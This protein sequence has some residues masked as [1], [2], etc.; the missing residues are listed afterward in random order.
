MKLKTLEPIRWA[1]V[2]HLTTFAIAVTL[3][4]CGLFQPPP[5]PDAK[6]DA[7][8]ITDPIVLQAQTVS[9][10]GGINVVSSDPAANAYNVFPGASFTINFNIPM[11]QPSV[12]RAVSLFPSQYGATNPATFGKLNLTSMC[13]GRWRV[14]NPN[15]VSVSFQWDVY[16]KPE[17]GVGVVAANSE[18]FFQ[19]SQGEK[20]VRLFVGNSQQNTKASTPKRCTDQLFT[21]DWAKDSKSVI[22]TPASLLLSERYTLV[23][24]TGAR[25]R[26]ESEKERDDEDDK[27]NAK[28][29][30][31]PFTLFFS[32]GLPTNVTVEP[33]RENAV[34]ERRTV[35]ENQKVS[36]F[37]GRDT[38]DQQRDARWLFVSHKADSFIRAI[39]PVQ[40]G[41]NTIFRDAVATSDGRQAYLIVGTTFTDPSSDSVGI[42]R[43][44]LRTG[45]TSRIFLPSQAGLLG[46]SN[47]ALSPNQQSLAFFG[48]VDLSTPGENRPEEI[49]GPEV[50]VVPFSLSLQG[51]TATGSLTTKPVEYPI[52][53]DDGVPCFEQDNRPSMCPRPTV[54]PPVRVQSIQSPTAIRAQLKPL[55]QFSGVRSFKAQTQQA[56][57]LPR[58]RFPK[59]IDKDG[60]I[61]DHRIDQY[62]RADNNADANVPDRS[63][64]SSGPFGC[65]PT[66]VRVFTCNRRVSIIND[67]Y[68]IDINRGGGNTDC[69]DP[70]YAA[71]AGQ[72]MQALTTPGGYGNQVWIQH[73]GTAE[74]LSTLYAHLSRRTVEVGSRV[75]RG[76]IIGYV[77]TTG[78]SPSC[79]LHFSVRSGN[80]EIASLGVEPAT[81]TYP[82]EGMGPLNRGDGDC[83]I[84]EM[85]ERS[86]RFKPI[87]ECDTTNSGNSGP[88]LEG[89]SGTTLTAYAPNDTD[90]AGS[91]ATKNAGSLTIKNTGKK[92]LNYK[93]TLAGQ[94]SFGVVR[95]T[96]AIG[97][98]DPAASKAIPIEL[99]CS[100]FGTDKVTVTVTSDGGTG[101]VDVPVNCY[102]PSLKGPPPPNPTFVLESGAS[103]QKPFTAFNIGNIDL[104]YVAPLT[105][106]SPS[107]AVSS[108]T[109]TSAG[110]II[111]KGGATSFTVTATCSGINTGTNTHTIT[112][113]RKD[114]VSERINLPVIVT[115]KAPAAAAKLVAAPADLPLVADVGDAINGEFSFGNSGDADMSFA[116]GITNATGT[117]IATIAYNGNPGTSVPA[118]GT[119][120]Q[121]ITATCLRGG[122]ATAVITIDAQAAGKGTTIV[123][124][125]CRAP[126]LFG[127]ADQFAMSG[128]TGEALTS[129]NIAFSN[130]GDGRM[131]YKISLSGSITIAD[132]VFSIPLGVE[133][134]LPAGQ[135]TALTVTGTCKDVFGT[136]AVAVTIEGLNGGG[137]GFATL[138]VT[139]KAPKFGTPNPPNLDFT[140]NVGETQAN[141]FTVPNIGNLELAYNN[142]VVNGGGSK[143]T[144]NVS[145]GR[146]VITQKVD[147]DP[148][149]GFETFTVTTTC[150]QAGTDPMRTITIVRSDKPEQV[151]I[152]VN[153]TCKGTPNP[154]PDKTSLTLEGK[155]GS[156]TNTDS[157]NVTN[158]AP[159]AT[160]QYDYTVTF[161]SNDPSIATLEKTTVGSGVIA[162]NGSQVIGARANCLKV[163]QTGGTILISGLPNTA[164]S[165]KNISVNVGI[166]CTGPG[167]RV[168][169]PV[170]AGDIDWGSTKDF[171]MGFV[172]NVAV[173]GQNDSGILEYEVINLPSWLQ[174]ISSNQRGSATIDQVINVGLRLTCKTPGPLEGDLTVRA[175]NVPNLERIVHVYANCVNRL[176]VL[177]YFPAAGGVGDLNL[178][179]GSKTE[180]RADVFNDPTGQGVTWTVSPVG[181][182]VQ[183]GGRTYYVA[184]KI[185]IDGQRVFV[186][187][188]SV[189]D[190][191]KS[192]ITSALLRKIVVGIDIVGGRAFVTDG[193]ETNLNFI[194]YYDGTQAGVTYEVT[195]GSATLVTGSGTPGPGP[196][197]FQFRYVAPYYGVGCQQTKD[198]GVMTVTSVTD[199]TAF[200]TVPI[201]VQ[202]KC[203]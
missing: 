164:S 156:S 84:T 64:F 26:G 33:G 69:G 12:E 74:G 20:T 126:K 200:S 111:P 18:A 146:G 77:G 17:Q 170:N 99:E 36:L 148:N 202:G 21:F 167:L 76:T 129:A 90:P 93:I 8:A 95:L 192:G 78:N 4:S 58:I 47:I 132:L 175:T 165:G 56:Q 43:I 145:N 23:I 203:N 166:T 133:Q 173:Q 131:R 162:V 55:R 107:G 147:T 28:R 27:E 124:V 67:R 11:N 139:C 16:K 63:V 172:N 68:A 48:E 122:Q 140:L 138:F 153:V 13:N 159:L 89:P 91:A 174:I 163:G 44:D 57:N 40:F 10:P 32:T 52:I 2:K 34:Q 80:A 9:S 73:N 50:G 86:Y 169:S 143:A 71:A 161:T 103:D 30:S 62:N 3:S 151:T 189:A 39:D 7:D 123:T 150:N 42:Y 183:E 118:K 24:S 195:A 135:G 119:A 19:T 185:P 70:V 105:V 5:P 37:L 128:K 75:A 1:N 194:L 188:T 171:L 125:T 142:P 110:G 53:K 176:S 6:P 186:K 102:G 85:T 136:Q 96:G 190:P 137:N 115:C 180:V 46:V 201:S 160:G 187:A 29:L 104:E 22:I 152:T 51:L 66:H 41:Q 179:A 130:R 92:I 79:H 65:F 116:R 196:R 168:F 134:T 120:R 72:V 14:Q 177:A 61:A 15:T 141:T 181:S 98:L 149:T 60:Q 193:G 100:S 59:N 25:G 197:L 178:N 199:P 121:G 114:K 88:K 106:T 144:V 101:T 157:V 117:D 154:I 191:S 35:F 113:I 109:V 31:Q 155:S 158:L 81:S 198:I 184:P 112:L 38:L 45:K 87:S 108:V 182:I 82:M 97:T 127:P 49:H 54:S 94:P 83:P